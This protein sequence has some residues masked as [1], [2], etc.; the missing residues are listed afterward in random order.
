MKKLYRAV[1]LLIAAVPVAAFAQVIPSSA[2]ASRVGQN[3]QQPVVSPSAVGGVAVPHTAKFQATPG[4]EKVKFNLQRVNLIG[5]TVYSYQ[6]LAPLF[7]NYVGHQ[8]SLADLENV[9][10]EITLKYRSSGYVLSR[11][12]I[13]AQTVKGGVVSIQ[14][15]EGYVGYVTPVGYVQGSGSLVNKYGQKIAQSKP[16]NVKTLERYAL[17]ANDIPGMNQV[18]VV[19]QPPSDPRAPL[20]STNLAFAP[21]FSKAS[22]FFT[23]DNRGTKYLG[24]NEFSAGATVNSLIQSGDQLGA[25]ALTSNN[26]NEQYVNAFDTQPLGATGATLNLSASY[27]KTTPGL[28]LER[29][30]TTGVSKEIVGTVKVPVIR[31]RSQNLNANLS[32]D[33]LNSQ[34]DF[35]IF[36][37]PVN[38]Y[39]D[40]VRSARFGMDY[41]LQDAWAGSNQVSGQI[42]HGLNVLGASPREF[43][44]P[45]IPALS[46]IQGDPQYTKFN[47]TLSRLQGVTQNFSVLVAGIGQYTNQP[48]LSSE[49]FAFGGAQYGQ[50]YDPA[51]ITGDRGVAAKGELRYNT[52]PGYR[53]FNSAQYYAFYDIGKIWNI[54]P[55]SVTGIQQSQSASSTGLGARVSFNPYIY[56]SVVFAQPLTRQVATNMSYAPRIFVSIT[57]TGKTPSATDQGNLPGIDRPPIGY[58][59]GGSTNGPNARYAASTGQ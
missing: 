14:V 18:K 28:N 1:S 31:S 36:N 42:S 7:Q 22:A 15:I 29:L 46:R 35:D 27:S 58:S 16:L 26:K 13:P 9:A 6:E 41:F 5:N 10:H 34:T 30:K 55:I 3:L 11:A 59:D 23:Y 32:F 44:P 43:M 54:L 4:A 52:N 20:G 48:L 49:Q 57:F 8:V 25:Q 38:V 51:E 12:I 40:H 45:P 21:D 39:T 37:P 56:G 2:E 19:L 17:L 53:F 24:Q 47:G 50:A 33:Y